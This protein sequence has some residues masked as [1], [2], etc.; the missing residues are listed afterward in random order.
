MGNFSL[1]GTQTS[2]IYMLSVS[3]YGKE[4]VVIRITIITRAIEFNTAP[5]RFNC[6][7]SNCIF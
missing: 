5:C 1:A 6:L 4:S 2:V 3:H 7:V